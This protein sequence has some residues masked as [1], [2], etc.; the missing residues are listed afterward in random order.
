MRY[1][2][3]NNVV[4]Q[5]VAVKEG[6]ELRKEWH[7]FSQH[8]YEML[9]L[10]TKYLSA[11]EVVKFRDNAL[12]KYFSNPVYLNMLKE[13]FGPKVMAHIKEMTQTRLRRKILE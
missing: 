10:P 13:K 5:D 4:L 6:W 2:L 7:G 11:K 1:S 12:H 3:Q 9:P 8:S